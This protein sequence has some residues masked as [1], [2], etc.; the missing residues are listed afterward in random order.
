MGK[1][2]GAHVSARCLLCCCTVQERGLA[3]ANY[4]F[5]RFQPSL[6]VS[7]NPP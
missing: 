5:F 2:E 7:E 4:P 1:Q 6:W 3:V